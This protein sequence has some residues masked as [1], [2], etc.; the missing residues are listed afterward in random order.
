[1]SNFLSNKYKESLA[2]CGEYLKKFPDGRYAGDMRYRLSF[3]DFNDKGTDDDPTAVAAHVDKMDDKIIRD[4]SGFLAEHP[5]D[6]ANGSMY[7]LLG[8]TYKRKRTKTDE[9]TANEDKAIESYIKAI[10]TGSPDDVI[11]YALDSATNMLKARKD[12]GAV[13]ELRAEFLKRKPDNQIALPLLIDAAKEKKKGGDG[14]NK[15]AE[16]VAEA[17][18]PRIADPASD[19]AE[20]LIDELVKTLVP[21]KK[22][23]D[24]DA[25]ELDKQLVGILDKIIAGQENATTTAR[26]YYARARLAQ[27]LK[28]N[29]RCDLYLKAIAL[30]NA[31]DSSALSPLL[32]E[33]CGNIL[34]KLGDLDGAEAMFKRL[35]DHFPN[36]LNHDAGTVGLG[37]VALARKQ[38]E[39]ALKLFEESLQKPG[40]LQ[41]PAA[42]LG[43]LQA[44]VELDQLDAGEKL[45]EEIIGGGKEF[46][47]ETAGKA[48]LLLARIYRRQAARAG[49]GNA[50]GL[51][52][53][54]HGIYIRVFITYKG[55][56]DISAEAI[57]E[58]SEVAGELGDEELRKKNRQDLLG[59]PKLEGTEFFKKAAEEAE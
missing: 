3:I 15:V 21:K 8:D 32:L 7:C 58:A 47:G 35:R 36:A 52:A 9:A 45:A 20:F 59:E 40:T 28:R 46:R 14:G 29:D 34:L 23:E 38:P 27:L 55:F 10:W 1:M 6:R 42:S 19:Q 57:W 54:A 49:G 22:T 41:I 12:W 17:L 30:K 50:G 4:I 5:D 16:V 56:L 31:E 11:Q 37:K 13:A 33:V 24:L 44:L 43:K 18:K 51:L 48:S 39:A 53:K 2:S 25:D 26:L